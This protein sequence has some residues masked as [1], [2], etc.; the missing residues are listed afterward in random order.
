MNEAAK[1]KGALEFVVVSSVKKLVA[2]AA[3]LSQL[4]TMSAVDWKK[5]VNAIASGSVK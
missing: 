2:A 1:P 3:E 4:K 5:R